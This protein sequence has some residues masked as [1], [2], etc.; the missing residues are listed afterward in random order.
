MGAIFAIMLAKTIRRVKTEEEMRR[1]ENR[2][3]IYEQLAL[4]QEDKV[5]TPVLYTPSSSEA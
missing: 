5:I 3:R 4:G 2:Q 1:Q